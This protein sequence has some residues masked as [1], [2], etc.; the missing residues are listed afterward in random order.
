MT[1]ACRMP[2]KMIAA[3]I[4]PEGSEPMTMS[5]GSAA[6]NPKAKNTPT[7]PPVDG[8]S[9]LTP[10]GA[11]FGAGVLAVLFVIA[12]AVSVFSWSRAALMT[13]GVYARATAQ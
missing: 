10:R 4:R 6:M 13:T 11:G 12:D 7:M 5:T 3:L 8:G 1:H 9:S 2:K